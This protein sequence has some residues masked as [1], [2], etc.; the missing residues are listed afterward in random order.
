[1]KDYLWKLEQILSDSNEA[2][3]ETKGV[4]GESLQDSLGI[5][6]QIFKKYDLDQDNVL[7]KREGKMF[8]FHTS[9]GVDG[10]EDYDE[11][12]LDDA[13]NSMD[14]NESKALEKNEVSNF[15]KDLVGRHMV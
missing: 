7:D 1:M 14:K 13:F 3:E 2:N 12:A 11:K 8:I 6:N 5:I 4:S 15:V 10:D 9:M